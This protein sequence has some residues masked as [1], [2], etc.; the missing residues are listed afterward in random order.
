MRDE[1]SNV[2][3][4]RPNSLLTAHP[5]AIRR[6]DREST[7]YKPRDATNVRAGIATV[8]FSLKRQDP[9][10][11]YSTVESINTPV[12]KLENVLGADYRWIIIQRTQRLVRRQ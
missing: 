2:S 5:I 9:H 1:Q 3:R 7:I 10:L 12:V 6:Y 11:L 8:I 4:E